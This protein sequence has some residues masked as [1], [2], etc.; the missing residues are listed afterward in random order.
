MVSMGFLLCRFLE[1]CDE[2][3]LDDVEQTTGD[4]ADKQIG[5]DIHR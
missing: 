3:G 2:S 1:A 4:D 5:D